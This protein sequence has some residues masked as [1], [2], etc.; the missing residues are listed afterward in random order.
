MM[1][2]LQNKELRNIY[3]EYVFGN[4][5]DVHMLRNYLREVFPVF[6]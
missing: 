4:S 6:S 1:Q 2:Y 3:V 5:V